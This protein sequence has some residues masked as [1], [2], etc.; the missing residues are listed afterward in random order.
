MRE[1]NLLI[2]EILARLDLTE[3]IEAMPFTEAAQGTMLFFANFGIGIIISVYFLLD[4]EVILE[5]T[6]KFISL[7]FST[8]TI[9]RIFSF[10]MRACKILYSFFYGQA[11]DGLFVGTVVAIGFTVLR[12]DN[13]AVHGLLF[14]LFSLIPYFGALVGAAV[15]TV[16][17]LISGGIPQAIV[18]LI[19]VT[20]LQQIDGN[21][22]N[23]KIIGGKLRIKPILVILGVTLG[24]GMFGLT[25]ML[26]GAPAMAIVC[27]FV[28]G[29]TEKHRALEDVVKDK[30]RNTMENSGEK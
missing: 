18:V 2:D 10:L 21:Y 19:F 4:R 20:I 17:A 1:D 14:G 22:V 15:M 25:G 8:A 29:F 24:G 30:V 13:A 3:Y 9:E 11:L 12:I 7:A 23:P 5:G 28:V 6:K 27:E 26:L 16:L